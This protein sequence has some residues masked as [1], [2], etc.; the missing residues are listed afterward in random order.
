MYVKDDDIA[1]RFYEMWLDEW[2]KGN[3]KGMPKDQPSAIKVNCQMGRVIQKLDDVWNVQIIRGIRYM[4]D[5]KICHY[6]VCDFNNRTIPFVLHSA[7]AF[8]SLKDNLDNVNSDFYMK[9]IKNP[10]T[11]I[12]ELTMLI[13]GDEVLFRKTRLYSVLRYW[14]FNKRSRYNRI[15]SVMTALFNIM[16]M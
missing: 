1:H 11:D 5:A 10:F 8:C 14:Y 7:S 13:S 16:R 2:K 6:L 15:Q 9:L 3:D 12:G 4:K